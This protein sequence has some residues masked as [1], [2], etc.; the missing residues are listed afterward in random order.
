MVRLAHGRLRDFKAFVRQRPNGF[1]TLGANLQELTKRGW[2]EVKYGSTVDMT[3]RNGEYARCREGGNPVELLAT[4]GVN[5]RRLIGTCCP[6]LAGLPLIAAT[7]NDL[8]SWN[9]G[10][11]V[12]KC[13]ATFAKVPAAWRSIASGSPSIGAGG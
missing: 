1:R 2:L 10:P 3:R 13:A 4:Y 6:L 7:Q 11:S 5:S 12:P 8:S 9:S